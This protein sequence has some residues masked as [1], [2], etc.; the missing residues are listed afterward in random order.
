MFLLGFHRY[1]RHARILCSETLDE[2]SYPLKWYSARPCCRTS[3]PHADWAHTP[4][5]FCMY[6]LRGI[7]WLFRLMA[8]L[9]SSIFGLT[10]QH[11]P[12]LQHVAILYMGLL[13]KFIYLRLPMT[14]AKTRHMM[15]TWILLVQCADNSVC[16]NGHALCQGRGA[17]L[18]RLWAMCR[19]PGCHGYARRHHS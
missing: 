10:S 4:K 14:K 17:Q 3:H 9:S 5:G 18:Q 6:S 11:I 13:P 8:K 7:P 19:W 16:R 15:T 12:T 1:D 2:T